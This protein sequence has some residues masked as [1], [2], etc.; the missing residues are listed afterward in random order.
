MGNQSAKPSQGHQQKLP[1]ASAYASV[2][3]DQPA[4]AQKSVQ[5][6]KP[7]FAQS[8]VQDDKPAVDYYPVIKKPPESNEENAYRSRRTRRDASAP[9]KVPQLIYFPLRLKVCGYPTCTCYARFC[10]VETISR[11]CNPLRGPLPEVSRFI[12]P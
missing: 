7:A 4:V 9:C 2:Q 11:E 3:D 5:N 12:L 1:E 6:D 10:D 8:S